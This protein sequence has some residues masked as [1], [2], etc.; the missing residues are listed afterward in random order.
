MKPK[1]RRQVGLVLP[2][3][4]LALSSAAHAAPSL[5]FCPGFTI[6]TAINES[7]MDYESIKTIEAVDKD[8]VRL[9]Y[10]S[11]SVV[12]DW[13][14]SEQPGT[15]KKTLT[16]RV[17]RMKDFETSSLYLQHF[18]EQLPETVPETTAISISR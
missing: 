18:G 2:A 1:S 6:V 17:V 13:L 14:A 12:F 5:P 3:L 7:N 10:S 4:S 15:L 8:G 11:E 9:R 16:H